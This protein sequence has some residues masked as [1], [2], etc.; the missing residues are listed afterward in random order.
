MPGVTEFIFFHLNPA[1]KPEDPT[2]NEAGASLLQLFKDTKHQNGYLGSSWGRSTEDENVIV[3]VID[4]KDA[5]TAPTLIPSL[6]P[7]LA[8]STPLTTF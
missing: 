2:N 6:T 3:W 8:P 5:Q 4:W 1:V 7:Y